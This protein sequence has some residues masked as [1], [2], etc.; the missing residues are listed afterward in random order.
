MS[1]QPYRDWLDGSRPTQ[2]AI[3]H[4][5]KTPLSA[6]VGLAVLAI[7]TIL[8]GLGLFYLSAAIA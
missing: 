3:D 2:S 4:S 1:N 5:N 6:G 8:V 7:L